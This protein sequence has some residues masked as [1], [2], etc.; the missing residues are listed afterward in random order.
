M[1]PI[2]LTFRIDLCDFNHKG[3]NEYNG[4]TFHRFLPNN[5]FDKLEKELDTFDG[6]ISFWF[7][8]RGEKKDGFIKYI[9]NKNQVEE[10][11][12]FRQAI[13]D[14]GLLFGEVTISE[15]PVELQ[16]VLDPTKQA[17]LNISL[18]AKK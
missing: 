13:L 4:P 15:V 2:K 17:M 9:Y 10:K 5:K 6:V 11:D 18:L 8:R 3:I 12:I 14:G 7:E 16:Q 1:T